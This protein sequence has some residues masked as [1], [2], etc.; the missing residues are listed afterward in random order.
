[1]QFYL[2]AFFLL[3]IIAVCQWAPF[4]KPTDVPTVAPTVDPTI[5]PTAV[6]TLSLKP[7]A[8]TRIPSV[9]PSISLKPSRKPS[10][11]PIHIYGNQPAVYLTQ[12]TQQ[13]IVGVLT[14]LLFILMAIEFLAPEVLFLIALMIVTGC[15]IISLN[16][17]FAG[18]LNTTDVNIFLNSVI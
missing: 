8:P 12:Q 2:R 17:A 10:S 3:L 18:K 7:T 13:I 16:Q 15:Q 11:V 9:R 1:M 6:P 14:I 4:V 5:K